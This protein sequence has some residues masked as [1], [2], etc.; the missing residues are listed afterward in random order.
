MIMRKRAAYSIKLWYL[1]WTTWALLLLLAI[2]LIWVAPIFDLHVAP[3]NIYVFL[4]IAFFNG[5]VLPSLIGFP[6][7]V[8]VSDGSYTNLA[9]AILVGL[10]QWFFIHQLGR[11]W[12]LNWQTNKW[13]WKLIFP[14]F[15]VGYYVITG[16]LSI[17]LFAMA[18]GV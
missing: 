6:S 16:S 12:L 18:V 4:A 14:M 10:I 17:Y 3:P 2:T 1:L 13:Y 7:L 11:L 8:G 5:L 9:I 15:L